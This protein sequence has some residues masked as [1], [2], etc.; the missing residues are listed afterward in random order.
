MDSVEK[1]EKIKADI[2]KQL[3]AEYQAVQ[4][5]QQEQL[6]TEQRIKAELEERQL[7]TN[8]YLTIKEEVDFLMNE[9][10]VSPKQRDALTLAW[11]VVRT[12]VPAE[13]NKY[14]VRD[15]LQKLFAGKAYLEEK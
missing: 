13:T 2:E 11:V 14:Q 3:Q 9:A 7:S 1:L 12:V 15:A 10:K 4:V 5:A 6:M 8:Y